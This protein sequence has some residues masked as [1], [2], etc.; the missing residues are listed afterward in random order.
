MKKIAIV[1]LT[2]LMAWPAAAQ[3]P[4]KFMVSEDVSYDDNIYLTDENTKDSFISSTQVGANYKANVPGSG[5]ELSATGLV[6]YNAYTEDSS[7]NNYWNALANVDLKNDMFNIGDNFLY[8]SDPANSELTERAERINNTG[9]ISFKTSTEKTLGFGLFADDSYDRYFQA[10]YGDDLNRNR[11]N[12]G[13]KLFYNVSPKTN[14]F[15]E[16][17]YSDI[18]YETNKDNNSTGN[19]V[20]LGVE[21]DITATVNGIAKVTYA[22]RDYENDVPGVNN[23]NDLFGYYVALQWQPTDRNTIRLSGERSMQESMYGS[24]RYY[25]DTL[26]SLYASQKIFD[27]WTASL[28]LGWENMAYDR[29][30]GNTK[31][32]DDLYTIRPALDYQFKDWL[33]AG[34]WYQFRTRQSN[35]NPFDYNRNQA[36]IYAKALF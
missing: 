36:G 26:V 13:A 2:V 3:T 35:T 4:L 30:E 11:V 16:Y 12:V 34:V 7:K 20:G 31:R 6:G 21:G 14:F 29:Y 33:S 32:N 27:K 17:M 25:A 5:L 22:M 9:Y 28:T 18:A 8:T 1:F 15:A 24:N 23:Y 10:E 19:T